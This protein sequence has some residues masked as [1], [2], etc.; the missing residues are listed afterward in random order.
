MERSP[1]RRKTV[2]TLNN[3]RIL[4]TGGSGFIGSSVCRRLRAEGADVHALSRAEPPSPNPRDHVRWWRGDLSDA[5]A[6]RDIVS[7]VRP[8]IILHLAGHTQA[9]RGLEQVEPTFQSNLVSTVHLLSAASMFGCRRVVLTGSLEEPEAAEGE[10]VPSSPY[11]ASKWAAS[12]YGRM[13]HALYE[14]EVVILRVFMVYGAEQADV[15]KLIPSVTLA[16]L[17]GDVPKLSSGKRPVDWIYVDDVASAFVA[18]A[19]AEGIGG[20]TIEIGSGRLVT[21]RSVVEQLV[22]LV[23]SAGRVEFGALPERPLEQVRAANVARSK[24]LLDWEAGV[25]LEEGLERTVAWYR[26]EMAGAQ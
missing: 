13:F 7:A 23:D 11:A 21:V 14:L 17:R 12:A 20:M 25:S 2:V 6:V 10:V 22:P 19:T 9:A 3:L 4:V 16:L 15:R 24:T 8:E 5:A 1:F 18:A 26:G